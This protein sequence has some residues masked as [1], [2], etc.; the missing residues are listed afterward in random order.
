MP[1]KL[2]ATSDPALRT[3]AIASIK[4]I[5]VAMDGVETFKSECTVAYVASMFTRMYG[6]HLKVI[7]DEL[8]V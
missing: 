5:Y 8:G 1:D 2:C 7:G 6:R 4:R 3:C